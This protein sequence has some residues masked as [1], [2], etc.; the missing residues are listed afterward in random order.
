MT[1]SECSQLSSWFRENDV[2]SPEETLRKFDLYYDLIRERSERMNLVSKNDLPNLVT[3]HILDSLGAA[4]LVPQSG[5]GIDIG[6]GAGFPGIPLA[7]IRPDAHF[8]LLES[9]HKK[10]LF[11]ATAIEG[12]GL[13]NAALLE[14]R[15]EELDPSD[16]Y[17][18]ATVRAL[19]RWEKLMKKIKKLIRPGGLVVFFEKRGLYQRIEVS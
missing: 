9:V 8:T 10:A 4:S 6:S 19:P 12:L 14:A 13:K 11:L 7:L 16:K 1:A 5:H 15:V 17:D 3:N 18:F 2:P